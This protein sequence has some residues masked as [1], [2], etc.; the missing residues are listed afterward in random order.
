MGTWTPSRE[1]MSGASWK[2][3]AFLMAPKDM[4]ILYGDDRGNPYDI[5][6]G[7]LEELPYPKGSME[8]SANINR[9]QG[10]YGLWQTFP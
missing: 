10:V 9:R 6:R 5:C 1:G 8:S 4:L 7:Y 3:N 2:K